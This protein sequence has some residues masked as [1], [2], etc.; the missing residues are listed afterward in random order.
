MQE[1]L[2]L[3]E[4]Y[5]ELIKSDTFDFEKFNQYVVVHNSNSIE[6]STLTL[7]E[8]ILL[9]DEN[10]TPNNR[11]LEH[12]FM[13]LDHL[14]ALKYVM[15][16]AKNKTKLSVE[17]V[18]KIS[19]LIMKS[20]GAPISAMAGNFDSSKGDFRKV[21]VRAGSRT[22][23]DYKKVPVY[24]E[25]LI[26]EINI[27]INNL[28]EFKEVNNLA[29]DAHF[30]MVSV[31]PFADGNGRLSR[32]LMNYVQHYHNFPLSI[33][34]P[35]DKANYFD[36][37]EDT[38]KREDIKIFRKFMVNQTKKLLKNQIKELSASP[39]YKNKNGMFFLF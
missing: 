12:T 17:I 9:L 25:N 35:S 39:M 21:T 11:P 13:A 32:L 14:E 38:R 29:F 8:T 2:K 24:T 10:L 34:Y 28:T 5:K 7:Q 31:H 3:F 27:K 37:L 36:A 6:G 4:Q 22:F 33:V 19:S 30:Q 1:L 15:E 26:K 16:L 18:Q 20:T 23:I